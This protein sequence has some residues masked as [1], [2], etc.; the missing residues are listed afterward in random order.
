MQQYENKGTIHNLSNIFIKHSCLKSVHTVAKLRV[1]HVLMLLQ[2]VPF[3]LRIQD[4]TFVD[5]A[6]VVRGKNCGCICPS[7]H[8]PLIARQGEEKQWHFAHASRKVEGTDKE[9]D[10]SFFVSVRMMARQVIETG[11]S[12]V[13]P[14]YRSSL[15]K[16]AKGKCFKEDFLVAKS[17]TILLDNV[18][19]EVLFEKCIVDV[20]GKVGE[21]SF[22]IYF[23]HPNRPLPNE[24]LTPH[25]RQ[26]GVLE[27]KLDD[28]H[29]LFTRDK[30][31]GTRQLDRLKD[32]LQNDVESKVWVFHPRYAQ[33]EQEATERLS[34]K[35]SQYTPPPTPSFRN[36][37]YRHRNQRNFNHHSSDSWQSTT[38]AVPP[39]PIPKRSTQFECIMCQCQWQVTLPST[40][41]CPKC[42]SHLY[43]SEV[44]SR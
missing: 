35:A 18:D 37:Q 15:T 23:T 29:H 31:S 8:T 28:T 43:A 17:S 32:Y 25:N 21:F 6:D 42:H 14:E 20:M 7:C 5:V 22:V 16:Q 19:K 12:I 2:H 13:L 39:T 4:Q 1:I 11:I 9:C 24:L 3:G 33:L 36:D 26:C 40:P 34:L 30:V 41:I 10:F 27:I 44:S 38:K